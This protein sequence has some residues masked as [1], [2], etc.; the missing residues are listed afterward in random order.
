[1]YFIYLVDQLD[2]SGTAPVSILGHSPRAIMPNIS[3]CLVTDAAPNFNLWSTLLS[4]SMLT[5]NAWMMRFKMDEAWQ[6]TPKY[7]RNFT[8]NYHFSDHFS[9]APE[10]ITDDL[11]TLI[12]RLKT[13]WSHSKLCWR[14]TAYLAHWPL[15]G[16]WTTKPHH[17][18]DMKLSRTVTT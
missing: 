15:T 18:F 1:M 3:F 17:P 5:D 2:I 12:D 4:T 16:F 8:K 11:T 14:N 7:H 9:H 10:R 13:Y 6:T